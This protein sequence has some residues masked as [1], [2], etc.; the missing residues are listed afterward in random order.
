V[1][2]LRAEVVPVELLPH[3]NADVLSIVN[4]FGYTCVVRTEDWQDKH[5]GV[6]IPVDAIVPQTE[7]FEFLGENRRIRARKFRGVFS[8]GLLMPLPTGVVSASVGMDLAHMLGLTKYEP[9]LQFSTGGGNNQQA[10]A[11]NTEPPEVNITY[12]DIEHLRR[13]SHIL[14]D[15]ESVIITEKIHGA[16]ARYTFQG[17]TLHVGSH[18]QWKR[19]ESISLWWHEQVLTPELREFVRFLSPMTLFGEVYGRV[20]D[21]RY[22]LDNGLAFRAFDIYNPAIG[23][24][25]NWVD[26][27]N[28]MRGFNVLMVPI[29]ASASWSMGL[30]EHCAEQSSIAAEVKEGQIMEGIVVKPTQ[31]RWHP[32]V[33][34]VVLKLHSQAYLLRKGEGQ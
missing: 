13:Y 23:A 4:V 22:G 11:E 3:P 17:G 20:Q 7:Q 19:E 32:E 1:S 9:P 27:Y 28:K 34:R 12:T 10:G 30:A 31:E 14:I 16:N 8:Q 24:Y 15:G 18:K 33:G 2:T 21:L 6:Y 29:L 25:L 26:F 5:L